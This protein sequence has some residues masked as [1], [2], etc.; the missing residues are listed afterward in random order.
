[1]DTLTITGTDAADL[2]LLLRSGPDT[3]PLLATMRRTT[4]SYKHL[5]LRAILAAMP[6]EPGEL[7]S[8][9]SLYRE[10]LAE[11]WWPAFHYRLSLGKQDKVVRRLE[12]QIDDPDE[13]RLRP[14]EV[15]DYIA[16]LPF[17][18]RKE[19]TQGLL[20]YVPQ[21]FIGS[22]F[23]RETASLPDS[24]RD[25]AIRD[26]AFERFDDVRP[27]YRIVD[28]GIHI[29][30]DWQE[31]IQS[32]SGVFAGWADA[33]WL[34]YLESKNPHATSL[35]AKI[36]PAFERGD[37][38][39]ER[40][41]WMAA[42]SNGIACIYTQG[43]INPE[44]FALD[45]FLPHAF[46]GHDR[47]WNLTPMPP[48]LNARKRDHLPPRTLVAALARQHASLWR[49]SAQLPDIERRLLERTRDDYAADLGVEGPSLYS[50]GAMVAAYEAAYDPLLGI[51]R[52]M[53]FPDWVMA[54]P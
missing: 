35:L 31:A 40:R 3:G 32:F 41:I 25:R 6:K 44:L 8:F 36:R 18:L 29:H 19:T 45:H 37:L 22:W 42:H 47:I 17:D 30:S 5:F 50:D 26:L 27:F 34:A 54:E 39:D 11:A 24:K 20:R 1:M 2:P 13:L 28:A 49:H 21:R 46:V 16:H 10:M 33:I 23:D 53:G 51:A 4:N 15:R 9:E 12:A 38:T 48:S 7:I 14:S 43:P 52:R